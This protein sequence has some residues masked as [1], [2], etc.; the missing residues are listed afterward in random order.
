[1]GLFN[2]LD[3]AREIENIKIKGTKAYIADRK[4]HLHC[5]R[6]IIWRWMKRGVFF[7]RGIT[8]SV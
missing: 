5:M 3:L 6:E 2:N 4:K 1:M 7:A 8:F